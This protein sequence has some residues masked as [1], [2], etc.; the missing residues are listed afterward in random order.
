[1]RGDIEVNL[2]T[3]V[4]TDIGTICV[5]ILSSRNLQR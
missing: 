4:R 1:M 3:A 5:A 2:D